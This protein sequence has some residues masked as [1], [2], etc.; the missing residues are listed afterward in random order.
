M[1]NFVTAEKDR[2]SAIID[3]CNRRITYN[4]D[5]REAALKA[6]A[7]LD[8]MQKLAEENRDLGGEVGQ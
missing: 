8:K 4:V 5:I 2:L 7:A 6:W 1:T 3:G